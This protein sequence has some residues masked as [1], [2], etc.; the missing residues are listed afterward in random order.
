MADS[1]TAPASTESCDY[2]IA[3]G[4]VCGLYTAWRLLKDAQENNRARRV[5]VYEQSTRVGGRL[6]SWVPVEGLRA[7]LG[8]MRFFEQQQLVRRLL[9]QLGLGEEVAD[10]RVDDPGPPWNPRGARTAAGD[11]TTARGRC[12]P[13]P[14]E[15][16]RSAV[17]LLVGAFDSVLRE[18]ANVD[19]FDQRLDGRTPQTREDWDEVKQH[20][21]YD[22]RKLWHV[23]FWNL[24][25]DKLSFEAY[26]HIVDSFGHY[27]LASNWNAAEAMRSIML[28]FVQDPA[29]KT[30]S[31]GYESLPR[32]LAEQVTA[33]GRRVNGRGWETIRR[34]HRL[35]GFDESGGRVRLILAT[36]A[37]DVAADAGSLVLAM[38]RRSLEALETTPAWNIRAD[39][40]LRGLV[41]SVKPYPAFTLFLLYRTRWWERHGSGSRWLRHGRS[42]C[43]PPIRQTYYMRPDACEESGGDCP[44][45]GVLMASYDD[46]RTVDHWSGPESPSGLKA[47]LDARLGQETPEAAALLGNLFYAAVGH[48]GEARTG[49]HGDWWKDPPAHVR[50]ADEKMIEET[51]E[52]LAVLHGI[53]PGDIP[54]PVIGAYADWTSDPFGGGWNFWRPRTDVKDVME[55]IKKPLKTTNAF[56]VG[57]AY[58]GEQGWV[59]GALTT[60]ESVLQNHLGVNRPDWLRGCYLGW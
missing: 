4:G 17:E 27:S 53:S 58:S 51:T 49:P 30:L 46:A 42:V 8:G 54:A 44:P 18:K 38:P 32:F 31:K 34:E 57:E 29:Y 36:G 25:A 40:E 35:R 10:V 24:L 12:L 5:V 11:D 28:E 21:T 50:K 6:L 47:E 39:H 1:A 3:G 14:G 52:Q 16:G 19:V 20:L 7:E 56:V 2:A 33:L 48:G 37:K 55:R 60:A 13:A 23:G 15:R 43:D 22:G 9:E 59:E 45:Y 41:R 26:D